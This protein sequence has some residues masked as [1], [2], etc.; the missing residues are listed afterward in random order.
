MSKYHFKGSGQQTRF[1]G[2]DAINLLEAWNEGGTYF[3]G[4][5]DVIQP[6]AAIGPRGD[7]PASN[8]D[9][10]RTLLQLLPSGTADDLVFQTHADQNDE[11]SPLVD[12]FQFYRRNIVS[13]SGKHRPRKPML[14]YPP[15]SFGSG[16]PGVIN[17]A[18]YDPILDGPYGMVSP[19]GGLNTTGVILDMTLGIYGMKTIHEIGVPQELIDTLAAASPQM[20]LPVPINPGTLI[21]RISVNPVETVAP[22]IEYFINGEFYPVPTTIGNTPIDPAVGID[23]SQFLMMFSMPCWATQKLFAIT[24]RLSD[25]QIAD[26][27]KAMDQ[28]SEDYR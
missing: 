24:R 13:Q 4:F 19:T 23:P 7:F 27:H 8:M 9:K 12:S 10:V 17:A 14:F 2:F 3:S 21:I 6:E 20:G 22:S 18:L 25:M 16:G 5:W 28:T 1:P 26:L 15:G 11:Q